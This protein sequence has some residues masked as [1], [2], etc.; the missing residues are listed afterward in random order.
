MLAKRFLPSAIAF[1]ILGTA[2]C[3]K[4]G[5]KQPVEPVFEGNVQG[6]VSAAGE[7][8][9]GVTVQ[10][11]GGIFL[12][13][14]TSASGSFTFPGLPVGSYVVTIN[15]FPEDVE[16]STTAKSADLHQGKGSARVDFTGA[17]KRDAAIRGAVTVEGTGLEDVTISLAGP[18]SRSSATDSQG[19]F[20]F[21]NLMR[22]VYTVTLSGFDPGLHAFPT[23]TETADTRNGKAVEVPF[24]GTMVPQP[25]A[26]P[27]G[28][29]ALA[30]GSSSVI[31]NWTD[32]S[33]DETR[34]EVHRK[35]GTEG[36]WD[37]IGAPDPDAVSFTDVG[38]TPNTTYGYRVRACNDAGCSAYTDEAAATT[39]DVPPNAPTSL[40]ATATGPY[41]VELTWTDGSDNEARF[42]VERKVEGGEEWATIGTSEADAGTFSDS[43]LES[44]TSYLYRV[45]ACNEVG[46]SAYS[47]EAGATT[48]EVPPEAPSA[49]SAAA[50]GSTTVALTWTDGSDNETRFE[51]ERKGGGATG[52]NPIGTPEAGTTSYGD[53]GLTPN[54]TYAYRV[55]A[56]N[57]IGC[58]AYSNEATT[59]TE[60]VP[61]ETPLALDADAD[62]ATAVV[63]SWT[64]ASDNEALF[65]VERK[66]GSSGSWI[67]VA[68]VEANA[69]GYSDSG[70]NPGTSYSYRIRACN[71]VGC[72]SFS[73]QATATTDE[74]PP[75][76]PSDLSATATGSSTVDLTWTDASNNEDGFWVERAVGGGEN[77]PRWRCAPRIHRRS[78]TR[79]FPLTPPIPTGS[80]PSTDRGLPPPPERPA[81]R[82]RRRAGPI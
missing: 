7:T 58:S 14:Q 20:G 30:D 19:A 44:N 43:G 73:N 81:Q 82:P 42:E 56:C 24:S 8:L 55:R 32:E 60:A 12:T 25:P 71:D 18:E 78:P 64:D 48:D 33:D 59:L 67:E 69:T 79:G 74:V 38:L 13:T 66:K 51:V 1:L 45:R 9:P 6:V 27:S 26:E 54:T 29:S 17:R 31:L 35:V 39:E 70:L 75:E 63:L 37:Q 21:E 68:T 41:G 22:G 16:F 53:E 76:A 61:P 11:T 28:L 15:G 47:G 36:S 80:S 77:F 23:T 4:G 62:G 3:D 34:F 49:L 46:C 65:R 10:L 72:S 5:Q 40:G 57:Q 50:T 52:W 2:S